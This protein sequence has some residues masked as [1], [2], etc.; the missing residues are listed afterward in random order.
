MLLDVAKLL[1]FSAELIAKLEC[2][3][4]ARLIGT[5]TALGLFETPKPLP[6]SILESVTKSKDASG[7]AAIPAGAAAA[8]STKG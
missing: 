1:L 2:A 6:T 3:A 5:Q 4:D 8:P 7:M